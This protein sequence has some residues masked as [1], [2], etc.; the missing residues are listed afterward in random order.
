MALYDE[1]LNPELAALVRTAVHACNRRVIELEEKPGG[2][3]GSYSSGFPL[4]VKPSKHGW[5]EVKTSFISDGPT[6]YGSPFGPTAGQFSKIVYDD[7]PELYAVIEYLMADPDLVFRLNDGYEIDADQFTKIGAALFVTNILNRARH[8]VGAEFSDNDITDLYLDLEPTLFLKR[9]PIDIVVPILLTTFEIEDP[10]EIAPGLRIEL[11]TDDMN[12]ARNLERPGYHDVNPMVAGAATHAMVLTSW[13]MGWPDAWYHLMDRWPVQTIDKAFRALELADPEVVPGYAQ[14]LIRP[15]GW[16][17]RWRA[18]LPPVLTGPTA[19]KY[20]PSFTNLGWTT[21]GTHFDSERLDTAGA[22]FEQLKE[23]SKPVAI[24]LRR[25][26]SAGLRS[27]DEDRVIDLCIG[28]EALCGDRGEVSYKLKMRVAAL[29]TMTGRTN[30]L[31]TQDLIKGVRRIYD[32]R[33]SLVHGSDPTK[34][35]TFTLGDGSR[36]NSI[37]LLAQLVRSCTLAIMDRPD[38]AEMSDL[39]QA[40]IEA[41]RPADD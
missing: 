35:L 39:D 33:S 27:S 10:V 20:P 16:A 26:G 40:V 37:D 23:T 3:V 28:L 29:L 6:D 25:L 38:I 13:S 18:D 31:T 19:V 24:A 5:P 21:P 11:M 4:S 41:L 22:I 36:V 8:T 1:P 15:V 2:Y 12:R 14:I 17:K 34:H 32:M 9:L 7:V 30:G